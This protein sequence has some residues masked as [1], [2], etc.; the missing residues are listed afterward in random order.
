M[1]TAALPCHHWAGQTT[2]LSC[3][4]HHKSLWFS[5]TQSHCVEP[6]RPQ[7]GLLRKTSCLVPVP[8]KGR[9]A[10]LEDYRPV[11]LTSHIMKVMERLVLAHLRPLVFPSQ[12]PLQFAY[13]PHVGVDDA[14]IYL[15]QKAYSSLDRPNT[16]VRIMFFDF[17][18]AFNTIQPRLLKAKLEG[19]RVS[20]PLI[21]W[22]DDYLTGRPQFVRLQN[23]VSG[24]L[25]SNIGAPQGTVLSPFLF[26]TYTADFQHCTESCHLQKFSDDTAIVGCVEGGGEAEYRDLVDRF[27]KWCGENCMQ[28]NVAKTREMVVDFRRNKPLLSPVC[29]GGTD[30]EVVSAYKYLGVTLDNKLDWSTNT[31]AVYKKGLSRLY[32]LR[33]LR[34]FHVCNKMLQMFYQSVVASTIFFAVVSWGAGIKA[35]DANKLK[36][37]IKK[38]ESVVGSKLV[39][40]EEVVEDRML[41][42]LLAIMDHPSHPLHKTLDKLRSSFSHR[43]IQPRCSKER[44]RKSFLPTAIRLFN[45]TS[46][47]ATITELH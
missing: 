17:S 38:A 30:V 27:V 21:T 18:S 46:V 43:L 33:R 28:L 26:T 15:L 39:T 29:I 23:C 7:T 1:H 41:A 31:Q 32:F 36:K 9:P 40:L 25:I 20:A 45:S 10:A 44:Y 5:S 11:A 24:R 37:L 19:T 2:T 47:R 6:W 13:Q 8:K 34:S 16:S 22:V 4:H 35:K 12:D 42:K 3:S 14:I